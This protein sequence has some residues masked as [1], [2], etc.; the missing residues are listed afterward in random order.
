M[1]QEEKIYDSFKEILRKYGRITQ[2]SRNEQV[3][4]ECAAVIYSIRQDYKEDTRNY[5]ITKSIYEIEKEMIFRLQKK[6]WHNEEYAEEAEDV[7]RK[8]LTYIELVVAPRINLS[9]LAC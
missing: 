2:K 3:I 5:I 9:S 1:H 7:C 4:Y 8:A 6:I